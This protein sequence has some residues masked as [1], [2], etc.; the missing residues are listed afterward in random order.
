MQ[1][2]IDIPLDIHVLCGRHFCSGTFANNVKCMFTS[3][4]GHIVDCSEFL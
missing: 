3:V 2:E 1:Y 4:S